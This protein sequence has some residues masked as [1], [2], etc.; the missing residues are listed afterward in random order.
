MATH[1]RELIQAAKLL[2]IRE[3]GRRGTLPSART[4]RSVST[5]YYPLF[6]F[7]VDEVGLRVVGTASGLRRRRRL[8]GRTISHAALRLTLRRVLGGRVDAAVADFL[9]RTGTDVTPPFARE[10]AECFVAAQKQR[11]DADYDMDAS[12]TEADAELL[13]DRVERVVSGWR[14]A[15]SPA[16]RDFK[17][18]LYVLIVLKGQLRAEP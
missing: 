8:L 6:Q 12:P 4:R 14:A 15:D 18:A 1:D 17:Q 10:L 9:I 5:A 16:D 2:L 11:H 13:V 7:I 3:V